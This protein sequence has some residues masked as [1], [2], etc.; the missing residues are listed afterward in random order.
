MRRMLYEN[1]LSLVFL[2]LCVLALVGQ[3][4]NGHR[5]YNEERRRTANPPPPIANTSGKAISGKP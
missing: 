1:S 4:L 5:Q 3:S 2:S